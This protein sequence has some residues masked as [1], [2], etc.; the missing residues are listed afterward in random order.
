MVDVIGYGADNKGNDYDFAF[1]NNLA[2]LT[3]TVGAETLDVT[4]ISDTRFAFGAAD[5]SKNGETYPFFVTYYENGF[6][7]MNGLE[8]VSDECFIW[9]IHVPVTVD[10]PVKLTYTV[11]LTNPQTAAGTYGTYDEDGSEKH[12]DLWTNRS[13]WL[14]PVDSDGRAGEK[15]AFDKPTVSYTV[16]KEPENPQ[17]ETPSEES[18][19]D[20]PV[21]VKKEK[22]ETPEEESVLTDVAGTMLPMSGGGVAGAR[23]G[24][25]SDTA[26]W[27]VL[28]AASILT[29]AGVIL[30]K[31]T[32]PCK[33]R[34][35]RRK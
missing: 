16:T 25:S 7:G 32:K 11:H 6:S 8:D 22:E 5:G 30:L 35:K 12:E 28:A 33:A 34:R 15:E 4:R 20:V 21:V 9:E 17:P 27:A 23:T 10:K 19:P 29:M 1:V 2:N 18:T 31:N 24:D 3:L 26:L 13:A 14:Y